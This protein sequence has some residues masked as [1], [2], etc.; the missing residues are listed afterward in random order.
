MVS[1][2]RGASNWGNGGSSPGYIPEEELPKEKKVRPSVGG[3]PAHPTFWQP[4][5]LDEIL[6]EDK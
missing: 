6:G 5:T 1:G 4:L 3:A 2:I